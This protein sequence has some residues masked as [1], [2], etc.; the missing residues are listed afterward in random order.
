MREEVGH[1]FQEAD[2]EWAYEA[3]ERLLDLAL[4]VDIVNTHLRTAAA[5]IRQCGRPAAELHGP[6]QHWATQQVNILAEQGE[7]VLRPLA[8]ERALTWIWRAFGHASSL[9]WGIAA[10]QL[11][12]FAPGRISASWLLAS[13]VAAAIRALAERL[14]YFVTPRSST[15]GLVLSSLGCVPACVIF[16]AL[17]CIGPRA[18][19]FLHGSTSLEHLENISRSGVFA[20]VASLSA[21]VLIVLSLLFLP[22]ACAWSRKQLAEL[23]A[24][25]RLTSVTGET[26]PRTGMRTNRQWK[27]EFRRLAYYRWR[28]KASAA[29]RLAQTFSSEPGA[30][31]LQ[32]RHG[33]PQEALA[34]T[35]PVYRDS[36]DSSQGQETRGFRANM[37][38][39]GVV[40]CVFLV[41]QL[42]ETT[43]PW[44]LLGLTAGVAIA[45]VGFNIALVFV[46]R[47][48]NSLTHFTN[49]T[50][51]VD[52]IADYYGDGNL[53][54]ETSEP[55]V[56]D[57][58]HD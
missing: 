58:R 19:G 57:R 40:S 4:P 49:E 27:G 10:L 39:W 38:A 55:V 34:W 28:L 3:Q 15:A 33:S 46:D 47:H 23:F 54:D 35:A 45:A 1:L 6:P 31:L 30:F 17:C 8:R 56:G 48:E 52:L 7:L 50:S 36:Y 14:D 25:G 22:L 18:P 13:A 51:D 20:S 44:W 16:I 9:L 12:G 53:D 21:G 41:T 11:L 37:F 29:S 2:R 26:G 5:G 43:A 24:V 32:E 42:R